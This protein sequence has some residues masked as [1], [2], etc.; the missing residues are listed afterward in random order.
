[1]KNE[2]ITRTLRVQENVLSLILG[3]QTL[4]EQQPTLPL[5]YR[6][7]GLKFLKK[8]QKMAGM[9]E[10]SYLDYDIVKYDYNIT[11]E[12]NLYMESDK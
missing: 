6:K 2:I 10:K 8:I 9:E 7:E 12:K 5:E 3:V 11:F 1:M 4:L